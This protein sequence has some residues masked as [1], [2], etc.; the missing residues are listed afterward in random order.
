MKPRGSLPIDREDTTGESTWE[1]L[2]LPT[3]DVWLSHF[4]TH[5]KRKVYPAQLDRGNREGAPSGLEHATRERR[6]S[7]V[8]PNKPTTFQPCEFHHQVMCK[9]K[10]KVVSRWFDVR[11]C[12]RSYSRRWRTVNQSMQRDAI[13]LR[14]WNVW[15]PTW[16]ER[17]R[18]P[19][20]PASPCFTA[21]CGLVVGL[22]SARCHGNCCSIETGYKGA[23]DSLLS[24]SRHDLKASPCERSIYLPV[25]K[26]WTKFGAVLVLRRWLQL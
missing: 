6:R 16:I 7:M 20:N 5:P 19:T 3:W 13:Q 21:I 17:D 10:P 9:A 12:S 22:V 15:L 24:L 2:Q 11:R 8:A 25:E 1:L 4:T 18:R 23:Q 14:D 26:R